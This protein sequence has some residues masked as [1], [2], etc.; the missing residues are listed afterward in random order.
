[1]PD[2]LFG[3]QQK[4]Y[5]GIA[6]TM[7]KNRHHLSKNRTFSSMT[8][9]YL[10]WERLFFTTKSRLKIGYI[11]KTHYCKPR[12]SFAAYRYHPTRATALALLL[13]LSRYSTLLLGEVQCQEHKQQHQTIDHC[14]SS[15]ANQ[16]QQHK[17]KALSRY[18]QQLKKCVRML[19]RALKLGSTLIPILLLYPL[20]QMFSLLRYLRG[21]D[22]NQREESPVL[23]WWIKLCMWCVERNG[24]A[25]VKL[26]QVRSY[27]C[28]CD[29]VEAFKVKQ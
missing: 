28:V 23:D 3:V 20:H 26:M 10:L 25:L 21:S 6:L 19:K 17:Y 14:F 2:L 4:M 11:C 8:K 29:R 12:N 15:L 1:M 5:P 22:L 7:T 24:A 27:F 16:K 13:P 9:Y 18:W